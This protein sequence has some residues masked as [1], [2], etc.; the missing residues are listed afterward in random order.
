MANNM[1]IFAAGIHTS[2]SYMHRGPIP[3]GMETRATTSS[4]H[5]E[6]PSINAGASAGASN[7][8]P[9]G[10][11]THIVIKESSAA[12]FK[13]A[14]RKR[15]TPEQLKE[16]TAVF[17]KTD[18][19]T[20]D[21]REELS[22]KLA[23][24]NREVQVWFQNRRAKYNRLRIEQQRQIRNNTAIIYT[25]GM[26]NRPSVSASAS[27][28]AL[29][30]A[31][32]PY[33]H[34]HP[35]HISSTHSKPLTDGN[36]RQ[37]GSVES[38]DVYAAPIMTPDIHTTTHHRSGTLQ[39]HASTPAPAF[40]SR[41]SNNLVVDVT[42]F[43]S[44][45]TLSLP[46][47]PTSHSLQTQFSA[48]YSNAAY[49]R[50]ATNAYYQHDYHPDAGSPHYT[51]PIRTPISASSA[52]ASTNV[53][54]VSPNSTY[55]HNHNGGRLHDSHK[56]NDRHSHVNRRNTVS[57]YQ[58]VA[59]QYG[60]ASGADGHSQALVHAY[61][62]TSP[63]APT[64]STGYLEVRSRYSQN[65][66]ASENHVHRRLGMQ[67]SPSPSQGNYRSRPPVW[68]HGTQSVADSGCRETKLPSIQAI[69]AET[70]ARA[71][72]GS[73]TAKYTVQPAH[74]MRSYTSPLDSQPEG[75]ALADRPLASG[76]CRARPAAHPMATSREKHC[77]DRYSQASGDRQSPS[78]CKRYY[79]ESQI[80][81][82]KMGIDVLATAAVSVSSVKSASL[83]PHL[84]PL[85]DI[86]LQNVAEQHCPTA[87]ASPQQQQHQLEICGEDVWQDAGAQRATPANGRGKSP[88]GWRPW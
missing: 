7:P 86:S 75:H 27:T 23:M 38:V 9:V 12:E 40:R 36:T 77:Q 73:R 17:E 13:K 30:P 78:S 3:G 18:T 2:S 49:A 26:I 61:A 74:R 85:S 50:P 32:A 28:S 22:S 64:Q 82:A 70:R 10:R 43:S 55:S 42:G 66:P 58:R 44:A 6:D 69:L 80:S 39:T 76:D 16:L 72:T 1:Q 59:G 31:F 71:D 54:E 67:R 5:T 68:S 24:T 79:Q 29:Q 41:S 53:V 81:E 60:I 62:A 57:S 35:H 14:K 84:T 56:S 87:P 15:I 83:L 63:L 46:H 33:Q 25:A 21:I 37:I 65:T 48:E 8:V 45:A 4:R 52:F 34:L 11:Y 88:R 51:Y 19:P 47:S 20:H